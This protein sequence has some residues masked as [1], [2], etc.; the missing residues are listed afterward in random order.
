MPPAGKRS[1]FRNRFAASR[2]SSAVS[3]ERGW[4]AA[5]AG[6]RVIGIEMK[7]NARMLR[8]TIGAFGVH[9]IATGAGALGESIASMDRCRVTLK[10]F[11]KVRIF[12]V[13]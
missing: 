9:S 2:I 3:G 8:M 4:G 5:A 10:P 7:R 11:A 6:D 12:T 1:E 13:Q